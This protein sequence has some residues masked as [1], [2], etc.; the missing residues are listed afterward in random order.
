[1][2]NSRKKWIQLSRYEITSTCERMRGDLASLKRL[3]DEK[4]ASNYFL[5]RYED[6]IADPMTSAMRVYSHVRLETPPHFAEWLANHTQ[7]S[8]DNAPEGT[9]RSNSTAHI[10]AWKSTKGLTELFV[11]YAPRSCYE[12]LEALHYDT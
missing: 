4:P 11:R 8:K 1:M 10:S 3:L 9:V 2:F 7:A 6:V 12:V 5:A